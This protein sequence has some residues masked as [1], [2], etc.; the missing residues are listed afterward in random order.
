MKN[1]RVQKRTSGLAK[2]CREKKWEYDNNKQRGMA[3]EDWC[4]NLL[5]ERYPAAE[6]DPAT[7]ILRG[8]D[9][10]IDIIFESKETEE[11][12]FVQCKNPKIAA[13]DPIPEDEVVSF[14][15][16]FRLFKDRGYLDSRKAKNG[17]IQE[18]ASEFPYW[19]KQ[20]Y[21]IHFLYISTGRATEKTDAL[22]EKFNRDN[23]IDNVKFEVWDLGSLKD[24]YELV[25]SIEEKYPDDVVFTLREHHYRMEIRKTSRLRARNYASGNG[26]QIQRKSFQLEYPQIF[27]QK[28]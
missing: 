26:T 8:D 20:G 28:R 13:Q 3:F 21:V 22:V 2:I 5:L 9:A 17:W 12:Y 25:A 14:F 6:N 15:F 10:R 1:S 24:E 27:G 23:A 11:I 16:E 18:L 4:F 19:L 7:S